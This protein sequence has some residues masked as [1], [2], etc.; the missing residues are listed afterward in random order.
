MIPGMLTLGVRFDIDKLNS[1]AYGIA[2]WKVFWRA[3][4]ISNLTPGT[5]LFEGD[6][7]ATLNGG[8]NVYLIAIQS[9]DP[10]LLKA[11]KNA[12]DGDNIF[13]GVASFPKFIED[14]G[15]TSEPLISTGRIDASGSLTGDA[16]NARAGL[17][18]AGGE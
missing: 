12:L 8:E 17:K 5:L 16:W 10:T 1:G 9:T 4:K 3:V 11:V 14:K 6:T 13:S 15:V 18:V 2:A 7:S